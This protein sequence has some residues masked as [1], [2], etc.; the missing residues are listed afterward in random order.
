M[1][2]NTLETVV[3]ILHK[4]KAQNILELDIKDMTTIADY[5]VIST[6]TSTVH[7]RGICNKLITE[8]KI[9]NTPKAYV[10]GSESGEWILVDLDD[11]IVNIMLQETRDFYNLEELWMN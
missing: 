1:N 9:P 4:Q 7:A 10:E 3:S 8:L 5:M 2:N 6:A 11:I